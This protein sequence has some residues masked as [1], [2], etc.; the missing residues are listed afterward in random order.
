MSLLDNSTERIDEG[1][2]TQRGHVSEG[3]DGESMEQGSGYGSREAPSPSQI[4]KEQNQEGLVVFLVS[5]IS[6]IDESKDFLVERL[7][8][9]ILERPVIDRRAWEKGEK[10]YV[11][12]HMEGQIHEI[13][14]GLDDV[15][16]CLIRIINDEIKEKIQAMSP[17]IRSGLTDNI[18]GS[19]QVDVAVVH[20]IKDS[21]AP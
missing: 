15:I 11:E 3:G 8:V 17:V 13:R 19:G 5:Q 21:L 7:D 1:L 20:L 16:F 14:V 2:R 10:E 18:P 12:S 6:P 9:P 4:P